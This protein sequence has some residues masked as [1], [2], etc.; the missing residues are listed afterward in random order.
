M[1]FSFFARNQEIGCQPKEINICRRIFHF[2]SLQNENP[3]PKTIA[4]TKNCFSIFPLCLP[5][6]NWVTV[7]CDARASL[8]CKMVLI[9]NNDLPSVSA[10]KNVFKESLWDWIQA[11]CQHQH[12]ARIFVLVTFRNC[13][14]APFK[15]IT[16]SVNQSF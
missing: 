5:L 9:V 12:H 15:L 1:R 4:K 14:E 16:S 11:E 13:S 3:K 2:F 6:G 8:S 7:S 10:S